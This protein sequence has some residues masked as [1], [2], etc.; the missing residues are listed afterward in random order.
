MC[1]AAADFLVIDAPPPLLPQRAAATINLIVNS[2]LSARRIPADEVTVE[3]LMVCPHKLDPLFA[4]RFCI[5]A[6]IRLFELSIS[7]P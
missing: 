2:S 4:Q 7:I 5:R 1:Y 6:C 3:E